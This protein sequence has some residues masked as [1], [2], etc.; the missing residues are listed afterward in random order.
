MQIDPKSFFILVVT[1]GAGGVA[2]FEASEKHLFFPPPPP[3]PAPAPV[4]SAAPPPA[5]TPP[6]PRPVPTC[7]DAVG[8][9]GTCPPPGWPAEEGGCGNL[10]TK[11]C[12][13]YKASF[14]PRVAERAVACINALNPNQRC[15]KDR[16]N[17]CGH[18]ALMNACSVLP[19]YAEAPDAAPDELATRCSAIAQ[20]CGGVPLGATARDCRDTL[21]GMSSAGRDRMATCMKTHCNDKG[22]LFCEGQDL[23]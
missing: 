18:E 17:L 4:V 19:D 6:P 2:G 15:D 16:L 11:R 21:A 12:E 10:P 9:A 1:L 13:D 23:K 7:D 22:L 20:E 14:R 8:A 3:P 5:P